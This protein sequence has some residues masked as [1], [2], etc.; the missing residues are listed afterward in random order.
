[1]KHKAITYM[2]C[3]TTPSSNGGKVIHSLWTGAA[4]VGEGF[5]QDGDRMTIGERKAYL[6]QLG[7]VRVR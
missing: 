5:F 1:M 2:I 3:L 6:K 4:Q 7:Y